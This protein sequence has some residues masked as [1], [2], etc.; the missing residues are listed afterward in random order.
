MLVVR[1]QRRF[2]GGGTIQ[3]NCQAESASQALGDHKPSE[4]ELGACQRHGQLEVWCRSTG[5]IWQA[6]LYAWV[7]LRHHLNKWSISFAGKT[8][9]SLLKRLYA[10]QSTLRHRS[11]N[12]RRRLGVPSV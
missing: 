7:K 4:L 3:V 5:S 10:P 1:V 2:S 12:S 11:N 9:N 6:R 8:L